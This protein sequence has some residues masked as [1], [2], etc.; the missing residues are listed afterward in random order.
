MVQSAMSVMAMAAA[1]TEEFN[2][3]LGPHKCVERINISAYAERGI[4]GRDQ[5]NHYI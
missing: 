3:N 1:E 2:D 4:K 5:N